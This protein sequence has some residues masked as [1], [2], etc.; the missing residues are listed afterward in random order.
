MG[1]REKGWHP[2]PSLVF[3]RGWG[4]PRF[5]LQLSGAIRDGTPELR[6]LDAKGNMIKQT[7]TL[8]LAWDNGYA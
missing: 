3:S 1:S 8:A 5:V 4:P 2:A 7:G 6:V